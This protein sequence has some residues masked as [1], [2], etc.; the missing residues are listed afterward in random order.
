VS[1]LISLYGGNDNFIA[2]LDEFFNTPDGHIPANTQIAGTPYLY[3]SDRYYSDG[4][5]DG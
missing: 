5:T 1:G 2:K 3:G 4:G